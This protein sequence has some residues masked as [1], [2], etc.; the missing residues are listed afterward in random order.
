MEMS[1]IL[2][3]RLA[4]EKEIEKVLISKITSISA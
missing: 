1:Q 4:K 2:E 3:S